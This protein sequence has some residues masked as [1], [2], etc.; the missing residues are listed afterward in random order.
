MVV[1]CVCWLVAA[2]AAVIAGGGGELQTDRKRERDTQ[3]KTPGFTAVVVA[4]GDGDG[5]GKGT[6]DLSSACRLQTSC[7]GSSSSSL[8]LG[9]GSLV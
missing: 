9:V 4:G 5:D 2:V 3:L 7:F 1:C 6:L 8:K